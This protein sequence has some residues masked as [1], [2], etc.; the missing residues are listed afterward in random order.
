MSQ[1]L[2][3]NRA[4]AKRSTGP[5]T[6][7]GKSR[8]KL[9]ALKHG[10]SAE[11]VVI[12]DEDPREFEALRAA[13]QR[14][15]QPD[16]ALES[17]LVDQLAG[18]FWR[19]RRVS[20]IEAAIVKA[21]EAE[22]YASVRSDVESGASGRTSDEAIERCAESFGSTSQLERA[23]H[24]GT[25]AARYVQYRNQVLEEEEKAGDREASISQQADEQ[26]QASRES[27]LVLLIRDD[28]GMI[29][30]LSRYQASLI[31]SAPRIMQQLRL[32]KIMKGSSKLI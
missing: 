15:W 27:E 31:N 18:I 14:D 16:T 26:Y 28:D 29:E 24:D 6:E 3:A 22:A 17:E 21:R 10:L 32:H 20:A 11:R 30:K 19:L 23:I 7:A 9:N 2:E 1:R 25:Y 12:G 5:K 4:N 13:L 8:S